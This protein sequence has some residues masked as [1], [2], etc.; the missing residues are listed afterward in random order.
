[1]LSCVIGIRSVWA[2]TVLRA[3]VC[4]CDS[5]WCARAFN[6]F[7]I[8]FG[9]GSGAKQAKQ[10]KASKASKARYLERLLPTFFSWWGENTTVP[11]VCSL[12]K[13]VSKRKRAKQ[14]KAKQA[15]QRYFSARGPERVCVC[16]CVCVCVKSCFDDFMSSAAI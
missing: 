9:Q 14:S 6:I 3:C 13:W 16:V 2:L 5:F 12:A 11:P 1:M 8:F 10:S 4:A 7:Q 15:K